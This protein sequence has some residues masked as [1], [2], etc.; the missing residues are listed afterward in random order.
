MSG[1][2]SSTPE[3]SP[4]HHTSHDD[5][6]DVQGNSWTSASCS[7]PL[8]AVTVIARIEPNATNT[9]TSRTRA[10]LRSKLKRR[11][12]YAPSNGPSVFPAAIKLP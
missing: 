4:I 7:V 10:K 9:T 12:R 3:A 2:K 5:P 8:V 6:Y 11:K 1:A